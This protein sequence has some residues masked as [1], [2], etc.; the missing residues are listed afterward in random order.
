MKK[1]CAE[2][3]SA[4]TYSRAKKLEDLSCPLCGLSADQRPHT[5]ELGAG[6]RKAKC[7]SSA[8]YQSGQALPG[9][10]PKAGID[11]ISW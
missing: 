6:S 11:L 8:S 9:H 2:C 1:A 5:G 4:G 7:P 3:D 10:S